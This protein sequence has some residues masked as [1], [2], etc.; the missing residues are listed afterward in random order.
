MT[1]TAPDTAPGRAP[2]H[3]GWG[4]R[5]RSPTRYWPCKGFR[6]GGKSATSEET[7]IEFFATTRSMT[8]ILQNSR[9]RRLFGVILDW[10]FIDPDT[11]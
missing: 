7:E 9:K 11:E 4:F 5:S 10:Q 6:A 1:Q 3:Q 2:G 8:V